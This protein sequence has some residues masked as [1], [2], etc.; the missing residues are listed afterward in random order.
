M[1]RSLEDAVRGLDR[2]DGFFELGVQLYE[3]L[4]APSEPIPARYRLP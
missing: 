4:G 1:K 3:L 2:D